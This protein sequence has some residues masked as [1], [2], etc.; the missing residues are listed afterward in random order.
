VFTGEPVVYDSWSEFLFRA[1]YE[2]MRPGCFDKSLSSGR[3]VIATVN[4]D[5]GKI[6][7]RLAAGTLT[8]SKTARGLACEVTAA[9]TSYA[10]DL[11]ENLRHR[12]VAG[13]SFTFDDIEVA[14]GQHNGERSRDV[15]EAV[16][17]EVAWVS[18][19]AYEATTAGMGPGPERSGSWTL[20]MANRCE[21]ILAS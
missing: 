14:W 19:P 6:L 2:R 4:H 12:D 5:P 10:R 18:L 9:D 16:L 13:M 20:E 3:D 15:I 11:A 8:I 7:G 1:F 21:R 17:L